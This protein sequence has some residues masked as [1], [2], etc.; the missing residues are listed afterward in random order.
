M[1]ATLHTDRLL[2]RPVA[3][4]DAPAISVLAGDYDIAKMTGSI[5]HPF[6]VI[7]A[8]I[9]TMAFNAAWK[10]GNEYAYA[11][12][13]NGHNLMG[14]VSLF[15]RAQNFPFELGYWIGR[16]FWGNGYMT[17]ACKALIREAQTSLSLTQ[18]V[19]GVFFDNDVS[20]RVL[21]K[22][23]F[24]FTGTGEDYFS[25]ARLSHA[26]SLDFVLKL[27]LANPLLTDTNI[28]MDTLS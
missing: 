18:I 23:G 15:R 26:K 6:P 1:R 5:P 14:I 22:L 4:G 21:E 12:T 25:I 7:S 27:P 20:V 16:P 2:L 8:E 19:A 10:N 3:F 9:R 13:E 11:I 24:V 17:E 28:A